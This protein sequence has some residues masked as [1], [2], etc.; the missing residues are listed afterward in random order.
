[1]TFTTYIPP[2]VL[3]TGLAATLWLDVLFFCM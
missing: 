2:L 1:M 3:L